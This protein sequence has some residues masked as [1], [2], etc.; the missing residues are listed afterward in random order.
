MN[1]HSKILYFR[2]SKFY[3]PRN[4][5]LVSHLAAVICSMYGIGW[6]QYRKGLY[7]SNTTAPG[8]GEVFLHGSGDYIGS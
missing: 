1:S 4:G 5:F 7:Y 8:Y 6:L 3:S 2:A